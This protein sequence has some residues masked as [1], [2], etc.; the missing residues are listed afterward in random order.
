MMI[1]L[2]RLQ[3]DLPCHHEGAESSRDHG[4]GP[5]HDGREEHLEQGEEAV[6]HPAPAVVREGHAEHEVD[7]DEEGPKGKELLR[8]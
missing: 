5:L 2:S 8:V 1:Y 3:C 6:E 7:G 4:H